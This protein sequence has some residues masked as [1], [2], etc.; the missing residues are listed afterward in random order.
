LLDISNLSKCF[1]VYMRITFTKYMYHGIKE[2]RYNKALIV[3]TL[4]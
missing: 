4:L 3:Y 2:K 1:E